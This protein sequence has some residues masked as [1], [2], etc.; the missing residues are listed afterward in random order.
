MTLIA[1]VLLRRGLG[2][3]QTDQRDQRQGSLLLIPGLGRVEADDLSAVEIEL[4]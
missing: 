2:L 4:A 3:Q 1:L